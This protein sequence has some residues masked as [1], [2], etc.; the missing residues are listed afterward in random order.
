M[1]YAVG[2]ASLKGEDIRS[3]RQGRAGLIGSSCGVGRSLCE[4]LRHIA[5]DTGDMRY[6]VVEAPSQQMV[7]VCTTTLTAGPNVA[8]L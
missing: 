4:S 1:S 8:M 2:P 6:A 3:R 5:F 7:V